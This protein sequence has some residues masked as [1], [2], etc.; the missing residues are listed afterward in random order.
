M[1]YTKAQL[2]AHSFVNSWNIARAAGNKVFISYS[3]DTARGGNGMCVKV[4]GIGFKTDPAAP[5]YQYG[6]KTF[7]PYNGKDKASKILAAQAWAMQQ[8]YVPPYTEWERDPFNGWHPKGTIKHAV[9][10][11]HT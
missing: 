8:G 11:S 2:R 10:R 6:S 7:H 4:V 3:N 9:Q 1:R 5:W